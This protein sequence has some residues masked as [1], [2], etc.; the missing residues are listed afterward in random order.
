MPISVIIAAKNAERT[1]GECLESVQMNN[2]AEIIVVDGNSTDRTVNIAKRYTDR[3]YSDEG[4]GFNYAQQL[5]ANCA[6]QEYVA[7]VDS[8]IILPQGT[9]A[10]LLAE[11]GASDC[12]SMQ[13]SLLPASLSTYW[14]R[15]A[16]WNVRLLQARRSGG[17]SAAVLRRDTI[18]KYRLDAEVE[19]SS[20]AVLE[21][22]AKRDG[23]KLG[24]SSAVF[25]YHFYPATL[26]GFARQR[27]RYGR[28]AS[29]VIWK[30][31]LWHIGFWHTMGFMLY[32]VA[33]CLIKGKPNFIPYSLVGGILNIAGV[34]TGF[35]ELIGESLRKG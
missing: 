31:R 20:D 33:I 26:K 12:I 17:L 18:L 35:F 6:T 16:D 5:G 1:I 10:A 32:W 2:A 24:T 8:D 30:Y 21:L 22:S 13:A 28:D 7:Y 9:L 4:R 25:V 27:F 19:T 11:L 34:V 23:Q 29:R 15:A 3:M 14:E